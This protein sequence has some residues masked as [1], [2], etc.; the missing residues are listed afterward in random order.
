MGT[1]PGAE[2]NHIC[3]LIAIADV[4]VTPRSHSPVDPDRRPDSSHFWCK[5]LLDPDTDTGPEQGLSLNHAQGDRCAIW[6]VSNLYGDRG[7]ILHPLYCL[8]H[9]EITNRVLPAKYEWRNGH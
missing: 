7:A 5:G 9:M 1:L 6:Q 3:V 2:P 4:S 8:D